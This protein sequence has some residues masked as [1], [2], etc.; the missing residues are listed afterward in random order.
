MR[1]VIAFSFDLKNRL[2]EKCLLRCDKIRVIVQDSVAHGLQIA[3]G[4]VIKSAAILEAPGCDFKVDA[5]DFGTM[6]FTPL[7]NDPHGIPIKGFV[8]RTNGITP[9]PADC[10]VHARLGR[11]VRVNLEHAGAQ[12]FNK[13]TKRVKYNLP[14]DGFMCLKPVAVITKAV[15]YKKI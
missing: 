5:R 7:E 3:R 13:L 6:H 10:F 4:S 2:C 12:C 1:T 15:F 14:V 11:Q 8:M 9:D